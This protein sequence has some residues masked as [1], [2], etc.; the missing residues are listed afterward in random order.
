[1]P[2]KK[3]AP[4]LKPPFRLNSLFF[5]DVLIKSG[6]PGFYFLITLEIFKTLGYYE[7][8]NYK[9]IYTQ[10]YFGGKNSFFYKL[11]YGRFQ[12]LYFRNLSKPLQPYLREIEHGRVLDIGCAYG[13]MLQ[14]FPNTFEKFGIDISDHAIAEAQKRLPKAT[15]LVSGAEDKLPFPENFFDITICNDIIEHLNN[16]QIALENILKTLKTNGI[17]YI[18]TPNLNWTRKKIITYADKKEHHISLFP[19]QALFNLLTKTDFKVID[20]WTYTSVAYFFFIKFRSNL[21]LES[22]FICRKP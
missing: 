11:G 9:E 4:T 19:H 1:M 6:F 22:G 7:H 17:L 13:F 15:L 12:K 10:D 20:H 5:V 18:S 21:G 8:M 16:P 14:K 3:P 2:W